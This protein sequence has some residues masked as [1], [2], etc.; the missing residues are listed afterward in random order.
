M[1]TKNN[2]ST[3]RKAYVPL[4]S[5]ALKKSV[6]KYGLTFSCVNWDMGMA[7]QDDQFCAENESIGSAE[8][9]EI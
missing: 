5:R 8:N 3:L 1:V 9:V 7:Q 4:I 2:S 6:L